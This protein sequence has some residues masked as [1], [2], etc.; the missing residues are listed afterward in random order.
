MAAP[1]SAMSSAYRAIDEWLKA[2][3]VVILDGGIGS[4]L[5]DAGYPENPRDRSA[6]FTWG[7]IAI[8][9]APDKLVEVHRRYAAAGADVLESGQTAV[10]VLV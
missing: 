1:N 5:Q 9:E 10:D 2:G 6:N 4:E 3:D 8:H 7:S